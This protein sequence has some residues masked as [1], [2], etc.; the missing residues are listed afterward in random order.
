MEYVETIPK[1]A[2]IIADRLPRQPTVRRLIGESRA[3]SVAAEQ[4]YASVAVSSG[5]EEVA[6]RQADVWVDGGQL[7]E[8]EIILLASTF[9]GDI[10]NVV[11]PEFASGQ[12]AERIEY[13]LEVLPEI[14]SIRERGPAITFAH[15]PAPHQPAVFDGKGGVVPVPLTQAFFADSPQERDQDPAEFRQRYRDQLPYLNDRILA[16]I[17]GILANSAVPPVILIFA[18]HGSASEVDWITAQPTQVDPALLLERTGILFATLTPGKDELYPEDASPVDMFRLL[19]DAY[20]GTDLGLAEPPPG[21]GH[22]APVDA[23]VLDP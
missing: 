2:D 19:F 14:A 7:N 8:F 17:D 23:E 10:L 18:D 11:A 22:I 16:A 5:F 12:Q 1:M 4:G 3:F 21:G 9:A 15:V 20:F 6:G 13:N